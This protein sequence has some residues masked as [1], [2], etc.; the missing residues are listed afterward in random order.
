M[1]RLYD[2]L[3]SGNGYKV[4][5]LLVQLDREFERVELNVID[6]ETRSPEYR[7][8][9]PNVRIPML[10]CTDGRRLT[11][12]N[13]ILFYLAAGSKF[14]PDDLWD[15][16]KVLQWQNFEQYSHEPFIAVLRFWHHANQLSVNESAIAAKVD[17]GLHALGVM[18]GH[19]AQNNFFVG[20]RYTIADISLYAY[21]H[22]AHEGGFDLAAFPAVRAWLSRVA[23]QPGHIR[24]DEDVGKSIAWQ[25]VRQEP[26]A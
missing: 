7:A 13:A 21:T 6:R 9:N 12:S 25:A 23:E 20:D 4:R 22:V 24:I 5:L 17:G 10:E 26:V 16:A 3:E 18:E 8:R 14:L 1:L 11:E 19:L 15:R 2:C